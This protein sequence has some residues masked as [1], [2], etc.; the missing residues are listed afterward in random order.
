MPGQGRLPFIG[1]LLA[2]HFTHRRVDVLERERHL[3]GTLDLLGRL[4]ELPAAQLRHHPLQVIDLLAL[5]LDRVIL[6]L[7]LLVLRDHELDQPFLGLR[8]C[9]DIQHVCII[10]AV[11][12]KHS[13]VSNNFVGS[14]SV[15]SFLGTQVLRSNQR[16][17]LAFRILRRRRR[18]LGRRQSIPS[19]NID[20]CAA[21][22][23]IV[24]S[25]ACGQTN[26]PSERRL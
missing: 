3:T 25:F 20:N 21:L 19:N 18:A 8:Q 7:D 4:A 5:R 1:G 9:V 17:M 12:S 16:R 6:G 22:N 14:S 26:F 10:P 2:E 11:S 13:G 15:L 24:P 23:E